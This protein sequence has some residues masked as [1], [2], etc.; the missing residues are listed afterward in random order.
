MAKIYELKIFVGID[1]RSYIHHKH[2]LQG[3]STQSLRGTLTRAMLAVVRTASALN[4]NCGL[5]YVF[6]ILNST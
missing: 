3:G 6:E 5:R 4:L 2:S 1:W